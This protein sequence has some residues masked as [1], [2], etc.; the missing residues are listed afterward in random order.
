MRQREQK[1]YLDTLKRYER[2][3]ESKERSDYK[4]MVKRVKD[5]ED[6]DNLSFDRLKKLY[7]K[8]YQNRERKN[9][10]DIFKKKEE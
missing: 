6:L 10:D 8:Y 9:Y 1:K 5:D 2:K 3:F 4:M 7:E